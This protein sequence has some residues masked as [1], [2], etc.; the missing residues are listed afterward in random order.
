MQ[1]LIGRGG[2]SFFI[3]KA[4]GSGAGLSFRRPLLLNPF[5]ESSDLGMQESVLFRSVLKSLSVVFVFGPVEKGEVLRKAG[6]LVG[7]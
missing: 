5:A 7:E 2:P 1:D 6:L 3:C 4:C